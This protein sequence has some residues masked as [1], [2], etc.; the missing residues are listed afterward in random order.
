LPD[1]DTFARTVGR[2]G[3]AEGAQVVAYD[4][5]SGMFASRLWWMLRWVGHDAVAVL[6]GGFS[7]WVAEGRPIATGVETRP[8]AV[9]RPRVRTDML[10]DVAAVEAVAASHRATLVDA[11]APQRYRGE[12]EPLDRVAG[13][14]PGARNHF[15]QD[16]LDEQGR[17]HTPEELR[18]RFEE[19]VAGTPPHDI[20]CYCGSG[21]TACHNLLALEHAGIHGARLYAGSWSEWSADPA[22]PVETS[23]K[24]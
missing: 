20:V 16:N 6:D 21:V 9:F 14:I 13:H 2:L 24:T 3:I 11:R 19:V 23:A 8:A 7:R 17:F 18:T 5:H 4:Q 22:R 12:V 1:V 15:F 10:V